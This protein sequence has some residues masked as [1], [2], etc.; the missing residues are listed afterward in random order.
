M[1]K[2]DQ[3]IDKINQKTIKI[4]HL[5]DLNLS[6]EE[7]ATVMKALKKS[8]IDI[9][10]NFNDVQLENEK[11]YSTNAVQQY[12]QEI[13]KFSTLS[14]EEEKSLF[15]EY[16]VTKNHK[17]REKLINSNLKLVV[18]IAKHY[19]HKTKLNS[20]E[21][22]DLI[23]DGNEGLMKAI[24][25]YDVSLGYRFSTYASWWIRQVIVRSF[26]AVSRP[27]RI[28]VHMEE[29]IN[30][31]K[32]Y[33][34][35]E[36]AK[37][38]NNPSVEEISQHFDVSEEKVNLA[39]EVASRP[40]ISLEDSFSEESKFT[41]LDF[42]EDESVN[43]EKDY[44]TKEAYR[45]IREEIREKLTLKQYI[46]ISCRFGIVNDVNNCSEPMTLEQIASKLGVTRERIRQI[47]AK[48]LRKL[49]TR[50]Q[51]KIKNIKMI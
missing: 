37:T 27:V 44:I 42:T 41:V 18:S 40:T 29:F 26:S 3:I 4:E 48:A 6:E 7:F 34:N 11:D 30:K 36:T 50:E 39:L 35:E 51:S 45:E 20:V 23:Q 46:V 22:L 5:V 24:E 25:K 49:R 19:N 2:I 8:G 31:I 38:G 32:K 43:I 12:L 10:N 14:K 47:E 28:P 33:M 1:E 9:E 17:I 15:L 13:G 21:F 16:L